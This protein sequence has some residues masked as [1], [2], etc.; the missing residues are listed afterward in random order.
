MKRK[1]ILLILGLLVTTAGVLL[2]SRRAQ[3]GKGN[4]R[5]QPGK[6]DKFALLLID[7][8]ND[9][10]APELS[11]QFPNFPKNVTELLQVCRTEG[12]DVIHVRSEF[13]PNSA[14]WP[15][16][17]RV[18]FRSRMPCVRGTKGAEVLPFAAER[19]GEPVFYKHTFDAF[20]DSELA[21]YLKANNKKH[22]LLAGVTTD[23]CVLSSAFGAFNRGYM[24]TLV[25]DC[26]ASMVDQSHDFVR[27]NY[28]GFI[29]D[30]VRV[31][32]ISG[33]HSAWLRNLESP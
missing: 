23:V 2:L 31:G 1:S 17:Y 30:C 4:V 19:P 12:I 20:F 5:P 15:A 6:W 21:D 24:L 29:F 11:P 16:S 13:S 7:L 9:F 18:R 33:Q 27:A 28:E 14:D 32:G 25:E 8:Q 3:T 26:C 10:W 22:L